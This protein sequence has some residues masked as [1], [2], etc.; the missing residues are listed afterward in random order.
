[1]ANNYYTF[2]PSF[3]PGAKVRA[4]EVNVQY[5]ALETAFDNLPAAVDSLA[6]GKSTFA[7]ETGSG[8][9]YVV[10]MPDTRTANA[11]GDEVIF[12]ASHGNTGAV[13][14]NVDGIGAVTM[15]DRTGAALTSGGITSGRLYVATYD[16][17]N[18]RFVLDTIVNTLNNVIDIVQ[19]SS[20]DNPA[21][22]GTFDANLAFQ[23]ASAAALGSIGFN[24]DIDLT[25]ENVVVGGE[26]ILKPPVEAKVVVAGDINPSGS[27]LAIRSASSVDTEAKSI[28]FE[29]LDET[30]RAE[31]SLNGSGNFVISNKIAT[32]E[33]A[34]FVNNN[35]EGIAV[36]PNAEVELFYDNASVVK[37]KSSATGG[38][39][40]N[41][42]QTGGGF[43]RVLTQS[44]TART[45]TTAA[46]AAIGN[47][48]NT[49]AEK[50]AGFM[51][52][53]TT[54]G[55]PV[56]ASGNTDGAVWVDATGATAHTP[57]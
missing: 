27:T 49:A 40:A 3:V 29:H 20:T 16:S 42:A 52:F 57:V 35:E 19:G 12:F 45:S 2:T 24:S 54:T 21:S 9:A 5:Q 28:I 15:V 33:V 11:N 17:A 18:T 10:T 7:P 39:E 30:L 46:L 41:N 31:V 51:V 26:V 38:L 4:S 47:A 56:W 55:A 44:D 43:E 48:I 53:N 6:T 37:T 36:K 1:M 25:I 34:L 22:P 8:N 50:E 32:G 23:N 14:L 13:T